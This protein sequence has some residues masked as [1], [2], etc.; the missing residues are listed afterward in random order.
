M[1]RRIDKVKEFIKKNC[2]IDGKIQTFFTRNI[3]GDFMVNIYDEDNVQIDYCFDYEYIEV[4]GLTEKEQEELMN[5][6][7][8]Y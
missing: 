3:I 8:C 2:L 5:T 4:F 1:E 6:D 7:Y